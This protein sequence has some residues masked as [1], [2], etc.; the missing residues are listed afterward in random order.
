[1]GEVAP[2]CSRLFPDAVIGV[3]AQGWLRELDEEKNVQSRAW[4]G[5]PFWTGSRVLFVSDQDVAGEEQQL[6]R[7]ADEVPI[8]VVTRERMGARVHH[9]DAWHQIEAFPAKEVDPTGAGDVFAA[10]FL[11]RY[12]ETHD[13][14]QAT[15]FGSAASAC[16]V[17]AQGIEGIADRQQIEERMAAHPELELT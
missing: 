3:G 6:E 13:V 16:S 14:A 1:M 11:V 12:S 17:E 15:R 7:W 10:A 2:E 9:D 5:T 4:I 8:V